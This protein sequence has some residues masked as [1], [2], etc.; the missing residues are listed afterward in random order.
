MATWLDLKYYACVSSC[1][2]GF[3]SNQNVAGHKVVVYPVTSIHS[4]VAPMVYL[5]T[6]IL[7]V[8]HRVRC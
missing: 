8:A 6:P 4:I 1:E 5:T 2:K 7:I 3:K